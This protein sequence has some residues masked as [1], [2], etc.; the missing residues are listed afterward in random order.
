M[1]KRADREPIII[2]SSGSDSEEG[3]VSTDDPSQKQNSN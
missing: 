3:E 1:E 2:S